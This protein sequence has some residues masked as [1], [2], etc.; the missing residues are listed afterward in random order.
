M[1]PPISRSPSPVAKVTGSRLVTLRT[2]FHNSVGTF[3][4]LISALVFL[5][6]HVLNEMYLNLQEN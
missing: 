2:R 3:R 6:S 4:V 5:F 1:P